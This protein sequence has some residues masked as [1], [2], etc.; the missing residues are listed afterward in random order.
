MSQQSVQ[1]S[2]V[3]SILHDGIVRLQ[4][5]LPTGWKLD[6]LGDVSG[7]PGRPD[8]LL[9]IQDTRGSSGR[10]VVEARSTFGPRDADT[11]L[12]GQMRLL[13]RVDPYA[14]F[15]VIAPWL[16]ERTQAVLAEERI[17]YLDL[18]GNV[19]LQLEN[20]AIYVRLAGASANPQPRIR[21]HALSLR[22]ALAGRIV[23]LLTDVAP[24]Y[25]ASAIARKAGVSVAYVSRLLTALDAEALVKREKNG[26]VT[27]VNWSSLLEARAEDY[28]V[29]ESN[30]ARGYIAPSGAPALLNELRTTPY[31]A[32]TGS[33]A[34]PIDLRITAP[35]QLMIYAEDHEALRAQLRL[36]PA[37]EGADVFLLKAQDF[38]AWE[39]W[40]N[41]DGLT[42]ASLTQVALDCMT[43]NGRMPAEAAALLEWMRANEREWQVPSID[44]LP[45]RAGL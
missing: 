15:L 20:P 11:L 6:H 36:L 41:S 1:A 4:S 33:F 17:A 25:T 45:L 28:D 31:H 44:E 40:R 43:G 16:S 2:S 21:I 18:T 26:L 39:R 10:L 22:G 35:S 19:R 32:V 5:L 12:G 14:T 23:R 9:S 27:S 30:D 29:F 34:I 8:D 7:E 37:E 38:V 24:P 42:M 13:R 3:T